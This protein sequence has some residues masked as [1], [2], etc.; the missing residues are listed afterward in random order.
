[1]LSLEHYRDVIMGAIVSQITSL[2]IF[3]STIYSGA[4]QRKKSKLR[5]TGLCAGN[6]PVAVNSP[7]KGPVTR[8]MFPFDDVVMTILIL[9]DYDTLQRDKSHYSRC[10]RSDVGRSKLCGHQPDALAA[11]LTNRSRLYALIVIFII[12]WT[13]NWKKTLMICRPSYYPSL[14]IWSPFGIKTYVSIMLN[15]TFQYQL[16]RVVIFH[17]NCKLRCQ[18]AR[19][20][21]DRRNLTARCTLQEIPCQMWKMENV[22]KYVRLAHVLDDIGVCMIQKIMIMGYIDR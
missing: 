21:V 16:F 7:H 1:M 19:A 11:E 13:N 22:A 14:L 18:N 8:K 3:Y 5:V 12:I 15:V 10:H 20:P 9:H 6:S 2:T 4:D 17:Y